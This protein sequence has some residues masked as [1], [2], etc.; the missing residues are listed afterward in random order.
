MSDG[1][2]QFSSFA[3]Q[4]F[5]KH[6]G[7]RHTFSRSRYAN[8]NRETERAVQTVKNLVEKLHNPYLA[9][10]AY[11]K[12]PLRFGYSP[13]ELLMNRLLDTRDP[14]LPAILEPNWSFLCDFRKKEKRKAAKKLNYD[15]RHNVHNLPQLKMK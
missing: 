13:A 1:G 11:R 6:Y 3:F 2:L 9:L 15:N 12:S 14:I 5:T 7:F 4:N 8:S 10:L